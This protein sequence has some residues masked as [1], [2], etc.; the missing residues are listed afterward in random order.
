MV[1]QPWERVV[2]QGGTVYIKNYM[3]DFAAIKKCKV[4]PK[5]MENLIFL[6]SATEMESRG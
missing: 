3:T 1:I 2:Q 4:G 5:I 6:N